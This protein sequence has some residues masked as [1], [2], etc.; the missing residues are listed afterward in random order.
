MLVTTSEDSAQNSQVSSSVP[1]SV[2]FFPPF[3]AMFV[4]ISLLCIAC[5][6]FSLYKGLVAEKGLIM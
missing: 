5:R 3:S 6:L 1:F 4:Y 2:L